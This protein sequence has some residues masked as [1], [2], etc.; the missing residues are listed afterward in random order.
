MSGFRLT[1]PTFRG[2]CR[3]SGQ[4]LCFLC[5]SLS[6]SY[7][8]KPIGLPYIRVVTIYYEVNFIVILSTS[9]HEHADKLT[10]LW[11]ERQPIILSYS[12]N[13]SPSYCYI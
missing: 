3:A 4:K 11:S 8:M 7:T 5:S 6:H 13:G 2:S 1:V 10:Q 9:S 12:Q